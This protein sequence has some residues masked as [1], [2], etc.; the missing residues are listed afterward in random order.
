MD[1]NDGKLP[2]VDD[3]TPTHHCLAG[4]TAGALRLLKLAGSHGI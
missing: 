1:W 2:P 4:G 3:D